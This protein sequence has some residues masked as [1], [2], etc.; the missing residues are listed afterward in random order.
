MKI[1]VFCYMLVIIAMAW[2]AAGAWVRLPH[3]RQRGPWGA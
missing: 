2:V 1:P 3:R